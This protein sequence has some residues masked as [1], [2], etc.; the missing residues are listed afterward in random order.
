MHASMMEIR[1]NVYVPNH[2]YLFAAVSLL[3][4]YVIYIYNKRVLASTVRHSYNL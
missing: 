3:H 2:A 4:A 1:N